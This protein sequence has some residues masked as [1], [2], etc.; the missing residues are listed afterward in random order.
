MSARRIDFFLMM[1]SVHEHILELSLSIYILGVFTEKPYCKP[2]EANVV[3]I[4][5][6]TLSQVT[7]HD[8]R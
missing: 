3:Y 7:S 4:P 8:L 1:F 6:I 2:L 5:I